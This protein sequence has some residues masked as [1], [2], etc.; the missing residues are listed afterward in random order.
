MKR[1]TLPCL[2]LFAVLTLAALPADAARLYDFK[3]TVLDNGLQVITLEDF[4][5]P[6][7]AVQVWYQVGSKDENPAR[8]G[9]AHM[10]EHMMFR[11]TD[12]LGPEE[13]FRLIRE[14][15]GDANAFT[16]F[17]YTAYVNQLPANQLDLALWLEAERMTFLKVDQSNFETE[18]KVVEEERRIDLN[19]PYGTIVEKVL[20]V[21]FQNHP[22]RWAPIGQIPHLRAASVDELRAFWDRF[23]IPNNAALVVVGAI[24]HRESVA[25]AE[26]YLGWI[27]KCPE[28]PRVT[29]PEPPQTAPRT[30]EISEPVGPAPLVGYVYRGIPEPHPDTIPLQLL[31]AILGGGESSRLYEDLVKQQKVCTQVMADLYNLEQDGVF[32]AGAALMPGGDLEKTLAAIDG[33]LQRIVANPPSERELEKVKNQLRRSIVTGTMT[34]AT[35]ARLIGQTT[36]V[37]GGPDWL[38]QQL[39]AIDA[40]S[41]KDL[42][43]VAKTYLTP[44]R[45]TVLR[46]IPLRDN[47]AAHK[48][49]N[50]FSQ[51]AGG[52]PPVLAESKN[53]S[54][55][56]RP[57]DYPTK[58]PMQSLLEEL[59]VPSHQGFTLQNGL[60]VVVV[61]NSEVPF[62]TVKLG[63]KYGA[64]AE[65]S[66]TPGVASMALA[67]LTKGTKKY[68]AAQLAEEL[69]FNA[70]TL[71]GS[72]SMDVCSVDA[73]ALTD[74]LPH[75]V[76]LLAE[77][78]LRPTF[79]EN[80]FQVLREQKQLNL[81]I[82]EQNPGYLADRE[83][84]KQLFGEHPY[85]RTVD[86]EPKDVE[87]I[88]PPQLVQWWKTF[89]RPDAAIL[90]F[91][92]DVKPRQALQ[93]AR[94]YLADW[95]S[96]APA[97][98]ISLP[99]MPPHQDL[100]IYL[101][102]RPG[103]VQSQIRAGQISIT[104]GHPA[105]HSSRVYTQI[106][107]GAFDSRLNRSI[108]VE[109]GLTYSAGGGILPQRFSGTFSIH[110]FTK[111][112]TTAETVQAVLE[113]VR[114]MRSTPPSES[115]LGIAKS[116]LVGSFASDLETPQ[117]AANFQWI[118]DYNG[119]PEDY[120]RQAFDAYKATRTEDVI[121]V[122]ENVIAPDQLTIIVVGAAAA[123]K[124]SLEKIAP[125]TLVPVASPAPEGT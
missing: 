52:A 11:G 81:S 111:T 41:L 83:M 14:T 117:E 118:I 28:P 2:A 24:K 49:E 86:G 105:Y 103:S 36:M 55:L 4:S 60:K 114:G 90:Y 84:R 104:R 56:N 89:A 27:P 67:M 23:Y 99:T 65:D 112:A 32:G 26:K 37:Y 63:I 71:D 22:Y 5:C 45:R 107:G 18:R 31:M 77:V 8:Q 75:A 102:D 59:P 101:L 29:E 54:G 124:D 7:V 42:E 20:P 73:T 121:N 51:P 74:K 108:R 16:S 13:H 93:L 79:P 35:K 3:K 96:Q 109:K 30:A 110:T 1:L 6:I 88:T 64:Y 10:F 53:K 40:V 15:G 9:F 38:N 50:A 100:H 106:F 39:K 12:Q 48:E 17:D 80:E 95:E 116:Y 70:I 123:V 125:V 85:A 97:P 25:L 62:V 92:G 98:A 19:E 94:K 43:R 69:E 57:P 115:E 120:L 91:A 87:R 82:R 58:P 33:H 122:S 21:V 66:A 78:V 44:E 76:Q 72:A 68:T 61:P 119:L 34:V 46:V 113:V 47:S